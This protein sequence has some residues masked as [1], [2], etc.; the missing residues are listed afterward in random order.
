MT[1]SSA[2]DCSATASYLARSLCPCASA[3]GL[4]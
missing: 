4:S 3:L 1:L 2:M